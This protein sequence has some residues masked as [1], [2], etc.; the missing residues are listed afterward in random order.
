MDRSLL[1]AQNGYFPATRAPLEHKITVYSKPGRKRTVQFHGHRLLQQH[2]LESK[3]AGAARDIDAQEIGD[4][5][6]NGIF[7]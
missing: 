2:I 4:L 3:L 6:G 7:Q 1:P 5:H